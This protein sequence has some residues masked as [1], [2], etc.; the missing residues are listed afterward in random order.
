[1]K[2]YPQ[3]IIFT[4]VLFISILLMN[5]TPRNARDGVLHQSVTDASIMVTAQETLP[6]APLL[7]NGNTDEPILLLKTNSALAKKTGSA[8]IFY[9]LNPEAHWPL[10]S[11]TKLM[12]AVVALENLPDTK[13]RNTFIRRMMVISDNSAAEA[14]VDL[15]GFE[16]YI[17]LMNEKAAALKMTQTGFSD[18]TGLSY[19]NQSTVHDL[20]AL[21]NYI[22]EKHPKIFEW[23]REKTITINGKIY[24]NSNQFAGR[25]DF[26]GGK[27]G[28]TDE[29]NGNLISIF[30]TRE[31]LVTIIILG[32]TD[33]EER[34][35]Q[36]ERLLTWLL[37]HFK[38]YEY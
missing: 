30:K 32:A 35:T 19:L 38:H 15:Q 6:E 36:T 14:L 37:H 25:P 34:F 20:D 10:A 29:A 33:K 16:K 12:T 31:G 18:A 24:H 9:E 26:W 28:F 3:A 8:P 23:S 17:M 11:L 1:M 2:R 27:T 7:I 22:R 5:A 4:A 21:V 13:E